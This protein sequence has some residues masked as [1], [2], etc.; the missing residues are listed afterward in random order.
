MS[1]FHKRR[2]EAE[3]ITAPDGCRLRELVH[4]ERDA[5][6]VPYSLAEA[7]IEPGESTENHRLL[8]EDELYYFVLGRGQLIVNGERHAVSEGDSILVPR[9]AA[10][11]LVN[12]GAATLRWLN[13][14]SPPW[15]REHDAPA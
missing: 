4:P 3:L 14:V 2:H 9:G 15:R 1:L 5:A 13:I 10:Q 7:S 8:E 12:D 6:E 11:K